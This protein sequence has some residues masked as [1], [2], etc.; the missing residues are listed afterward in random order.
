M[1]EGGDRLLHERADA[2]RVDL[3]LALDDVAGDAA[4]EGD[5]VLL[6]HARV[7]LLVMLDG[8]G[9]G[10]HGGDRIRDAAVGGLL[11]LGATGG[12]AL[13]E[14]G[15]P[16]LGDGADVLLLHLLAQGGELAGGASA[17]A[18]GRPPR[19]ATRPGR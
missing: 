15:L 17:G 18:A 8:R 5:E 7:V 12:A 3:H 4:G 2:R 10:V 6:E 9:G 16:R 1:R 19:R 13:L 11:R 14:R